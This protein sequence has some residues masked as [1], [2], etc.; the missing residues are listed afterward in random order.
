MFFYLRKFNTIGLVSIIL[1]AAQTAGASFLYEVKILTKQE[2]KKLSNDD[3][4]ELYTSTLIEREAS[5]TFHGKA[6]FTPKE[7]AQFKELLGLI[8]RIRQEMLSRKMETPPVDE[9]L[10]K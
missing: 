8:V 7:Y 9:W 3:L 10:R 5:E 2:L 6:G 1:L 4:I